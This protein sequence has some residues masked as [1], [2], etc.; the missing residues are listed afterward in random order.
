MKHYLVLVHLRTKFEFDKSKLHKLDNLEQ[1]LKKIKISKNPNASID[2]D[3]IQY[4]SSFIVILYFCAVLGRSNHIKVRPTKDIWKKIRNPIKSSVMKPIVTYCGLRSWKS[5][6]HTHTHIR[7]PA[8]NH[9]SRHLDHSEYSD[10][11]I[12]IFFF[13]RKISQTYK[14][15]SFSPHYNYWN[16]YLLKLP[17]TSIV[18]YCQVID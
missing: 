6:T 7:A 14:K 4:Q 13:S 18:N 1:I 3:K 17:G 8:E 5:N 15:L 12:S 16:A 9:I 11:S 10:I 2:F